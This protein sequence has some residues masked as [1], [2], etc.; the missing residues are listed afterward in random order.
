MNMVIKMTNYLMVLGATELLSLNFAVTKLY[1]NK[2]GTAVTAG[3]YFNAVIGLA[4]G[5]LFWAMSGFQFTATIFSAVMAFAMALFSAAYTVIGFRIMQK[6]NM[7]IYTLFLMSGGMLLPYIYGLM[8]LEEHFSLLRLAGLL[9][10]LGA[11]F[12]SNG[13]GKKVDRK[14]LALCAATFVLNGFVSIVSKCHQIEAD[15]PAVSS[16]QF[17]MLTGFAKCILCG[18]TLI[19]VRRKEKQP[20]PKTVGVLPMVIGSAVLSGIS[21]LLQLVG[22]KNLPA[23]VLYPMVTSGSILFTAFSGK[24]FFREKITKRQWISIA[25]CIFGTLLFL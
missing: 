19:F 15:Y 20:L 23:T 4:S 3:L 14:L 2:E 12:L 5:I 11:V 8:F 7:A 22:A 1:Q 18:A 16:S 25:L 24:L 21:Y 17:V 9:A 13:K 10:I 6:G